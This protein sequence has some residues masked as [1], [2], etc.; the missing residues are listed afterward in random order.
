MGKKEVLNVITDN[1]PCLLDKH[2]VTGMEI[3]NLDDSPQTLES[4]RNL[5]TSIALELTDGNQY[6]FGTMTCSGHSLFSV[7]ANTHF[8]RFWGVLE[9]RIS[10]ILLANY[11]SHVIEPKLRLNNGCAYITCCKTAFQRDISG[12]LYF[13]VSR[14]YSMIH[15]FEK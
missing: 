6:L 15:S 5:K 1:W 4:S 8:I 7:M 3:I 13:E 12:E 10:N 11:P 9:S 2:K 14:I